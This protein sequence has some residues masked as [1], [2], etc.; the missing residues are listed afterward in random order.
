MFSTQLI[1][2]PDSIVTVSRR[3]ALTELVAIVVAGAAAILIA[4]SLAGSHGASPA[5]A[6]PQ[7]RDMAPAWNL[8]NAA[9]VPAAS[10]AATPFTHAASVVRARP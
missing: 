5:R 9:P 4:L 3:K 10:A 1:S 2:Y 8:T 6:L 7:V